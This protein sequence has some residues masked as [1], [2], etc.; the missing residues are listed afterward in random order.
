MA[1]YHPIKYTANASLF[2]QVLTAIV[3]LYVLFLKVPR[4]YLVLKQLLLLEFIVQIVEGTFYVWLAFAFHTI[5]NVTPY[6]YYDWYITTPTMLTT[7]SVYLIY[8]KNKEELK[9]KNTNE[10]DSND[11]AVLENEDFFTI[12]KKRI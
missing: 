8:L 11:H 3:D 5:Q 1:P 4:K 10:L 2:V 9:D 12:I 7:F 6:R